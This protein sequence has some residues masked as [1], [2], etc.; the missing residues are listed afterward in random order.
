M[1]TEYEPQNSNLKKARHNS[2]RT[3]VSQLRYHVSLNQYQV[4][5]D[6]LGMS[7][8]CELRY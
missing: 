2:A 3:H 6:N 1:L 8:P 5:S 7:H 4:K